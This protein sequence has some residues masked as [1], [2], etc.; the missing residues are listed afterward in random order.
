MAVS[1]VGN[2]ATSGSDHRPIVRSLIASDDRSYDQS[3]CCVTDRTINSSILRP[4]EC[5]IV[6]SATDRTIGR[7][8]SRKVVRIIG[9]GRE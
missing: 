6:A 7:T 1:V 4:I 8:T 9:T 5:P 3:S 2:C